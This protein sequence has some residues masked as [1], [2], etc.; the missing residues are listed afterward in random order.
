MSKL[1][2]TGPAVVPPQRGAADRSSR[3]SIG[4]VGAGAGG[5]SAA[6]HLVEAGHQVQLFEA[7]SHVGGLWVF[8]NDN[9]L[10]VA[11]ESL[12]INSEPL[13]TAYRGYPFP[14]GTP[15]FPSHREVA[16]YL[17]AFADHFD[18]RRRIRFNARVTAVRPEGDSWVITLD[19][20][21]EHRFDAVVVASGHQGVPAHPDWVGDYEGEY[22]H[23]HA[24]RSPHAFEGKRVL[25]VGV[26]NSGLDI[27]ADL[28]PFAAE[29]YSAAR[30]PVLIM[31]RMILGVPSARVIA[32]V[33]RPWLPWPLQR[34]ILTRISRVYHG[35]MEQWGLRTPRTR[36]HPASNATYMAHVAYGLIKVT[37]GIEGATGKT[38]H[39]VDGS[40]IEVDTVI[41]AT[42]YHIHLPF[43]GDLAPVTERRLRAYKRVVHPDRPGLYFVGF[44]NVSGGA[45]ISMM[46]VQSSFVTAVVDGAI[47]L[48]SVEAMHSDIEAER[49][50]MERR[51]PGAARYGLELD[52]VI[53]RK[54]IAAVL[55]GAGRA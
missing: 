53:Y 15:L 26:G 25:V 7:G 18:L 8:D 38:V 36:T 42:G 34:A 6:R 31:P 28:A 43:L 35:T 4:V 16:A 12:H 20:G 1:V 17:D 13:S 49:R 40:S 51:Y 23:S 21:S 30:S 48:P 41:A 3:K 52:P 33:N 10:S 55:A 50:F 44:F 46:D 14:P 5:L 32:K 27:A 29:T 37:P 22:L 2:E 11:Y 9:D 39:L 19:D 47:T 54:Q 24:Y 45:N